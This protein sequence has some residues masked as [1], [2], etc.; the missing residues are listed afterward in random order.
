MKKL[1]FISLAAVTLVSC[2]RNAITGRKQLTLMPESEL[3]QMAVTQY[4]QFLTQNRVLSTNV[5]KDAEMVRRV[6]QRITKAITEYYTEKGLQNELTGYKWEY[7]LVDDKNVNAWCMPG[8]KIVVYTGL[9][10]VTQNEAALAVVMGHEITHALAKH[11]NERMSQGMIQQLGG[12]AL[13]VAIADKP[14]E[15]Q[16]L[17][18][19]AYGVGSTVGGVLPFSRKH[20][21]E[22]DKFGLIYAAMAGYNPQE[23]IPLWERMEKMSGGQKPPEFMSTHPTEQSRIEKLKQLMPE[24]LKYYKPLQAGK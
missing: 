19:T 17:F 3:Q 8:G 16:N 11:G 1:L 20:E 14:A 6:G 15:T 22:A 18:M 4:Q 13:A 9:L 23:A 24:A 5:N 7:N 12:V 21:L 10:P 2:T